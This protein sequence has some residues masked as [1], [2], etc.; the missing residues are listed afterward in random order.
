MDHNVF[1]VLVCGRHVA[2]SD[3]AD[4]DESADWY[5]KLVRISLISIS[6]HVW[7]TFF[8]ASLANSLYNKSR[9]LFFSTLISRASLLG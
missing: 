2:K 9:Q 3:I 6:A 8:K 7:R 1:H 5:F 4:H